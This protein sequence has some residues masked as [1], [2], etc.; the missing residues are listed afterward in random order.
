VLRY[1]RA[2]C[3]AFVCF[4]FLG[5]T[6]NNFSIAQQFNVTSGSMSQARSLHTSTL[7]NDGTVLVAGGC[8]QD[9]STF[10]SEAEIYN[11]STG[12]FAVTSA[13]GSPTTLNTGRWGHTANLLNNGSVLIVGGAGQ[14]GTLASAEI[15]NPTTGLFQETGSLNTAR[16]DHTATTLNDGTV[17]ITGG[18]DSNN[19][20]LSSAEIYNPSTGTFSFVGSMQSQRS[21]H[22]ATL[23]SN[24]QVLV[25]GG[26]SPSS[27]LSTAEVYNATTQAFTATGTLGTARASHTA[28]LL[29]D[30][31]VLV[32]GG[33]TTNFSTISSAE[34]YQPS[35][36]AFTSTGSLN[37]AR[38]SH[39]AN[40]LLDGTV[41]IAGGFGTSSSV[42]SSAEIYNSSTK[43][44]TFTG[45][46][47]TARGSQ[48]ATPL[49]GGTILLTG[50]QNGA[51]QSLQSSEIYAYP[52]VSG[53]INP[54][55]VVLAVVYAPP[56]S[57]SNVNYSSSQLVGT[58]T[59]L[60]M[61]FTKQ[62]G[63]SVS[64]DSTI[65]FLGSGGTNTETASEMWTQQNDVNSTVSINTTKGNGVGVTGTASALGIDHD[66]DLIYIWLN[67]VVNLTVPDFPNTVIWNGYSSDP[68]DG[69]Q[70]PNPDVIPVSVF[71]LKDPFFPTQACQQWRAFE[72]RTWDTP[73]QAGGATGA[74]TLADFAQILSADPFANNPSYDPNTA[75]ITNPDGTTS[76]RFTSLGSTVTYPAPLLTGG[77]ATNPGSLAYTQT[78]QSGLSATSMNQTSFSIKSGAGAGFLAS[79][80]TVLTNTTSFEW[81]NKRSSAQTQT[82]AQTAS[83]MI[84]G[85]KATDNYTGPPQFNV[86]QDNVYGTFM[87]W[88][89][90]TTSS[91]AIPPASITLSSTSLNFPL[92][93]IG[94]TPKS[95]PLTLTNNS[96]TTMVMGSPVLSFSDPSFSLVAGSTDT[97]SGITLAAQASCNVQVEFSP[98]SAEVSATGVTSITGTL[99]AAGAEIAPGNQNVLITAQL[100]LNG[101][102]SSDPVG[103]V[104][105]SHGAA[106]GTVSTIVGTGAS[107]NSGDGGSATAAAI[108]PGGLG[109]DSG[110]NLYV[111][112]GRPVNT[113]RRIAP[114]GII[115]TVVGN[116]TQCSN[117]TSCGD[118]GPALNAELNTPTAVA[119]DL[120]GNMYISDTVD[121]RIRKVDASTGIIT[122]VVGGG[123][124]T[125]LHTPIGI[126]VD[127]IGNLYIADNGAQV[128]FKL[129]AS[130][131]VVT[132]IAGNG[133]AGFSGDGSLATNAELNGPVS[134]AVDAAGN[135]YIADGGNERIRKVALGTG[136]ITTVVGNGSTGYSG[137]GGPAINAT[138]NTPNSIATDSAGNVYISDFGNNVVRELIVANG[139]ITTV[140]GNGT[141]GF[142][143][144][145]GPATNAKLNGPASVLLDQ[146]SNLYVSDFFNNRVR[147]V[148]AFSATICNPVETICT[149]VGTGTSGDSGDG[150]SATAAAIQPGGLGM[151]SGGNLYVV[152]SRPFNV[153]RRIAPNGIIS[154]VVGNG[155]QC[156][157]STDACGDGGPAIDAQ[158]NVPTSVAFDA[159]GN[160]YIADTIDQRIRAV[161]ASTGIITTFAGNGNTGGATCSIPA[162]GDGGVATNAQLHN[163]EAVT[164]DAAGNVYFVDSVDQRIRKVTVSTGIISTVAG[165]GTAGF[166]G[167]GGLA[168][169]AQLN[170]PSSMAI[171]GSGNIY[172]ADGG[173]ER[174]RMV[175]VG[176]G[177]ITTVVGNGTA[178]FSGDGG[179]AV[180]ATINTPNGVATDPAGNVYISDFGNNAVRE[181]IVA[182]GIIMTVAGNGTAGF[183]GDGGPATNAEL[184]GPASV[185]LDQF[186]NLYISD[187]FNDRVREVTQ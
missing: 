78:S 113:I 38:G 31:T 167:D 93:P 46:L 187:F 137:D 130:T 185:L 149:I 118:G 122:T 79:I 158:L 50:G 181:L 132:T 153:I 101:S 83:Y 19:T 152:D 51:N 35:T 64:V 146:F 138:I 85:P 40:A 49:S 98:A 22:T 21:E 55:F 102:S 106:P 48:A 133:T 144:D 75:V 105:R 28:T 1:F 175:A 142:A 47:N 183:A 36:G 180:N 161:A 8:V 176:T 13:N 131:G 150:G 43:S 164:V 155:T 57:S 39:T 17:L 169:N 56:G 95:I 12:T 100:P 69:N 108:Q 99:I 53:S 59:S 139:I 41:L 23:L 45:P 126:A 143:G 103:D 86:Y 129:T 81:E 172:I 127:P 136:I 29:S 66:N 116:G 170:N 147:S 82:N 63:V 42:L 112:A 2:I 166:S 123:I 182:N 173:N 165:N 174:I 4:L 117:P 26:N 94:G 109:M 24:G 65:G 125:N 163:P 62:T 134:V 178:G 54:K 171:D 67:P 34:I 151:D 145:G 135:I 154:T 70:S 162:C 121:Q 44:F 115:T 148:V 68:N 168:T 120:S 186:S 84:V 89:P 124:G 179:P 14:L 32:A 111:V 33:N 96:S 104:A 61:A 156:A 37:T 10:L 72:N 141:G 157:G 91:F 11:P 9:C 25:T 77:S 7:L 128:V 20:P 5:I 76:T 15:Y 177:I 87:F 90:L 18:H 88:S 3:S 74:L 159:F 80:D 52:M 119:F 30:G 92:I 160:M 184:N 6:N 71:C 110:G 58:S 114:N 60:D 97:C 27:V 107:G 73:N 16:Y 140:A